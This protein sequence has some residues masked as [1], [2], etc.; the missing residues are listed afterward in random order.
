MHILKKLKNYIYSKIVNYFHK[1]ITLLKYRSKFFA[2]NSL[3][4]QVKFIDDY[5]KLDGRRGNYKIKFRIDKKTK[6][7]LRTPW[8]P[9]LRVQLRSFFLLEEYLFDLKKD[10]VIID[11]GANIGIGSIY[12]SKIY[13]SIYRERESCREVVEYYMV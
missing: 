8:L 10:P 11:A 7:I 6:G 5:Y 13:S 2:T 3:I 4:A 1:F 9:M 12:F